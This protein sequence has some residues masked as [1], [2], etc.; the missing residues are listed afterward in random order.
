MILLLKQIRIVHGR[1]NA[2]IDTLAGRTAFTSGTEKSNWFSDLSDLQGHPYKIKYIKM[3]D[4]VEWL[5]TQKED[6]KVNLY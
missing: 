3:C 1:H 6:V 5:K 4:I 2:K